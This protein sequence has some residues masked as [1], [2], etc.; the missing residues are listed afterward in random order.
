SMQNSEEF[1][2]IA[3]SASLG[4]AEV[5]GAFGHF[6]EH[7]ADLL[8][9]RI[10]LLELRRSDVARIDRVIYPGLGFRRFTHCLIY[11]VNKRCFVAALGPSFRDHGIPRARRT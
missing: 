9:F 3:K 6:V 5:M 7:R 11:F 2:P 4:F 8:P 1:A 10:E